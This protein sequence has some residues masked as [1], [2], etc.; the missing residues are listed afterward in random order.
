[1]ILLIDQDDQRYHKTAARKGAWACIRKVLIAT[2][3]MPVVKK[4]LERGGEGETSSS[5]EGGEVREN[6]VFKDVDQAVIL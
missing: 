4:A 2:E 1:M 6:N 5:R 3:L